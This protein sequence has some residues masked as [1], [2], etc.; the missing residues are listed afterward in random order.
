MLLVLFPHSM[1]RPSSSSQVQVMQD[2]HTLLQI[3]GTVTRVH[4]QGSAL[5][6]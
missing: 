2:L 3:L 5:Q 6:I 4:L 1:Q